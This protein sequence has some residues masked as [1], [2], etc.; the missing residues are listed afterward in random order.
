MKI[1]RTH[2]FD[3]GGF[4]PEWFSSL[5]PNATISMP[6]HKFFKS[7]RADWSGTMAPAFLQQVSAPAIHKHTLRLIALWARKSEA[8]C[9][10][11]S[12]EASGDIRA[13]T[14]DVILDIA[15]GEEGGALECRSSTIDK[16]RP[17]AAGAPSE[18]S[19]LRFVV[20]EP[21]ELFRMSMVLL[22]VM[23]ELMVAPLPALTHALVRRRRAYKTATRI[24]DNTIQSAIRASRERFS[25]KHNDVVKCAMDYVLS[26]E[27]RSLENQK[28]VAPPKALEDELFQFIVGGFD[29]VR[30][31]Q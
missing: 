10:V 13:V 1:R 30:S 3:R 31:F 15:L 19:E 9:G 20:S 7:Q 23:P 12:F 22:D 18:A 21:P 17:A 6:S 28:Q 27:M 16:Q 29:S 8:A 5:I 24:K 26:R 11:Q 25:E 14:F 4:L 2:E